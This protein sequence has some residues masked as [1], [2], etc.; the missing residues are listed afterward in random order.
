[1]SEWHTTPDYIVNN[2]SD[3][4]LALMVEKLVE[5]RKRELNAIKGHG[6]SGMV[7]DKELFARAGRLIKVE[8]KNGD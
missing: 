3:E 7:S 4:L 8:K 6:S 2:W 5:R 1:M